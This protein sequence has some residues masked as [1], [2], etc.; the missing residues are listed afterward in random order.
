MI[1]A[2][3]VGKYYRVVNRDGSTPAALPGSAAV[4]EW[5][6]E[7]EKVQTSLHLSVESWY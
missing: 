4:L 7:A 2:E 5:N 1:D 6:L 3:K